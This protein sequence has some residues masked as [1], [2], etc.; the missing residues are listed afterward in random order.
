M[1]RGIRSF[2]TAK[3]PAAVPKSIKR[4]EIAALDTAEPPLKKQRQDASSCATKLDET[5]PIPRLDSFLQLEDAMCPSGKH[6]LRQEF[7]KDYFKQLKVCL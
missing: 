5:Q 6:V 3:A 1:Q 7:A 4:V 2:F